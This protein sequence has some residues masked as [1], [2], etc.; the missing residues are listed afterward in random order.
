MG[1]CPHQDYGINKI[2]LVI[3]CIITGSSYQKYK[4][5]FLKDNFLKIHAVEVK[6]VL[7]CFT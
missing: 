7:R 5:N 4:I 1:Q 2:I 6:T 3:F